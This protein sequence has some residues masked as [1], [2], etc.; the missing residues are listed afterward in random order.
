MKRVA[1]ANI[2][3]TE[4][5]KVLASGKPEVIIYSRLQSQEVVQDYPHITWIDYSKKLAD[6]I[7]YGYYQ[8]RDQLSRLN[9]AEPDFFKYRDYNLFEA[10]NKDVFWARFNELLADFTL[11]RLGKTEI[12][13]DYRSRSALRK[14]ASRWK[15][16]FDLGKPESTISKPVPDA[17]GKVAIRINN[18]D[19][20]PMLGQLPDVLGSENIFY[21][22]TDSSKFAGKISKFNVIDLPQ[23][24]NGNYSHLRKHWRKARKHLDS[25]MAYIVIGRLKNLHS[26]ILQYENL[27]TSGCKS[28]L[29][30]AG[31]NDGEGHVLA[32]VAKKYKVISANFMNGTKAFDVVNRKAE[33]DFWFMHDETMQE[34][35]VREYGLH[36]NNLPVVGHLLEDVAKAHRNTGLLQ[37]KG[38]NSSYRFVIAFFTSPLFFEEN[39]EAYAAIQEF[40]SQYPDAVAFVKPH[41]HDKTFLWDRNDPRIIRLD[42][43]NEGATSEAVLFDM[44]SASDCSVSIASTVSFQASWF[45]IPSYT[46]ETDEVSRLPYTDGKRV[47]HIRTKKELIDEMTRIYNTETKKKNIGSGHGHKS[48]SVAHRIAFYLRS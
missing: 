20:F 46:F 38:L 18:P 16:Y 33:F 6:G 5:M 7:R 24:S 40:I 28:I 4:L 1:V 21:Y 23:A 9:D 12:V 48:D 27:C 3:T 29:I 47:I 15:Q 10:M 42:F 19:L 44:L 11:S 39:V 14:Y 34:L 32:Q 36:K 37:N 2:V 43:R 35:A 41:P 8:V 26:L 30:N 25:T 22:A 13:Y 17:K 31:E 45:G